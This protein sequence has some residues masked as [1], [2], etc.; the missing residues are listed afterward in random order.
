MS[1]DSL[2]PTASSSVDTT[3]NN[4]GKTDYYQWHPCDKDFDD[5]MIRHSYNYA[6]GVILK[7]AVTL[8]RGRHN[9]TNYEREL[10]KLKHY[11]DVELKRLIKGK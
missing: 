5:F 8:T 7:V 2:S 10:N 9:G 11:V 1:E 3:I 6:Q 4:G